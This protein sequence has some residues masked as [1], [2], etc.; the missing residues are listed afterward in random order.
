MFVGVSNVFTVSAHAFNNTDI[1]ICVANDDNETFSN[2]SQIWVTGLLVTY[3]VGTSVPR[4][5]TY[6]T[7]QNGWYYAGR[8]NLYS[9][10]TTG[11]TIF[12]WYE[13]WL[14]I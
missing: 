10:S 2:P 8:V 7:T 1:N 3:P 14:F 13:G 4:S 5:I 12:A 9:Q 11:S 6:G